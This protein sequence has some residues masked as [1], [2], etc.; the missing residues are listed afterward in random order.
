[1]AFLEFDG[2]VV[3]YE[4]QPGAADR[5]GYRISGCNGCDL[6][7]GDS[8]RAGCEEYAVRRRRRVQYG[9][10]WTGTYLAADDADFE[11]GRSAGTI[12]AGGEVR[13]QYGIFG[14]V[15]IC[16]SAVLYVIS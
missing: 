10:Q 13:W 3:E 12:F 8:E 6:Q 4:L 16:Y 14:C 1:M 7:H 5:G 9:H 15:G 11:C 2:H